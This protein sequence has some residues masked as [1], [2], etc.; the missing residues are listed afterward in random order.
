MLSSTNTKLGD[1]AQEIL[2]EFALALQKNITLQTTA[3]FI[4]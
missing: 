1:S 2:K 3:S 4:K